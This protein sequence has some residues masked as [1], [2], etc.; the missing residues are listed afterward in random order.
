MNRRI[1]SDGKELID[2]QGRLHQLNGNVY[3][4]VKSIPRLQAILGSGWYLDED[5]IPINL[6]GERLRWNFESIVKTVIVDSYRRY[7]ILLENGEVYTVCS[8][9]N[10]SRLMA[11]GIIHLSIMYGW[12]IMTINREGRIMLRSI[13]RIMRRIEEIGVTFEGNNSSEILTI[14]GNCIL[15]T[16]NTL[17]IINDNKE[18]DI[19]TVDRHQLPIPTIDAVIDSWTPWTILLLGEDR[20]LY[21]FS[22]AYKLARLMTLDEDREIVTLIYIP[23][24]SGSIMMFQD[25]NDNFFDMCKYR[26]LTELTVPPSFYKRQVPPK[27]S[28]NVMMKELNENQ[29]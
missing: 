12:R 27:S 20:Q 23:T 22:I 3:Q 9:Y 19:P 5:D 6:R 2:T 21:E 29:S 4:E 18:I 28:M 1:S 10:V 26:K 8:D 25:R 14:R 13:H 24:D 15:Y 16:D 17:L 11:I 7:Y